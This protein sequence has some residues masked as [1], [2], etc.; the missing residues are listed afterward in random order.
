MLFD[1]AC[2]PGLSTN[3]AFYG[4]VKV[5]PWLSNSEPGPLYTKQTDVL[6]QDLVKSRSHKIR[7]KTLPIAL[8][9]D[10]HLGSSAAEIP[11]K[12]QSDTSNLAA[13]RLHGVWWWD[14]LP[15]SE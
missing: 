2:S 13:L 5:V 11:V 1:L 12:F 7:V 9:S 6:P 4:G 14:V 8:K 3:K 10:R 15:L